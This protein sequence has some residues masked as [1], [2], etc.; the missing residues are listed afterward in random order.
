M[1]SGDYKT[2][3]EIREHLIPPA[4]RENLQLPPVWASVQDH[5]A[6]IVANPTDHQLRGELIEDLK[7]VLLRF[8]PDRDWGQ[9]RGEQRRQRRRFIGFLSAVSLTLLVLCVALAGLA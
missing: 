9:L 5:R 2:W 7:Q 6:R 8:Y 4:V 1:S 3:E